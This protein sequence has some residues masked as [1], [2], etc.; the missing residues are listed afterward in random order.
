MIQIEKEFNYKLLSEIAT[1]RGW[2]VKE[3]TTGPDNINEQPYDE[4]LKREIGLQF[5]VIVNTIEEFITDTTHRFDISISTAC[6]SI[7]A[8][9]T[10]LITLLVNKEDYFSPALFA[11]K[12][13][14]DEHLTTFGNVSMRYKF[15]MEDEYFKVHP[16][17]RNDKFRCSFRN[18]V[19]APP[20][21]YLFRG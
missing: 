16:T 15:M 2:E 8:E 19:A 13:I 1:P 3:N 12:I 10:F 18:P 21:N 11:V 5:P 20:G 7:N 4:L 14:A 6:I 17:L 9:A